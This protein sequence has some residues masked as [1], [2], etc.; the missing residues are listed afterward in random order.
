MKKQGGKTIY[1]YSWKND[2][3]EFS[4]FSY[5]SIVIEGKA[6][7]T[8]EHY[9]QSMKFLPSVMIEVEDDR[10]ISYQEHV[11]LA[12]T[13]AIAKTL[14]SNR[15]YKIYPDWD[16]RRI[17]VMREAVRAKFTQHS[18]LRELLQSTGDAVLVED[19]PYD[20][21]WGCGKRKTGKNMLGKIL[22]EV[23]EEIRD[24]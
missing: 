22:M 10:E 8:N 24:G 5:H 23:R 18:D 15:G 20:Y 2:Y 9:F 17:D 12:H 19:S 6:Y 21:F 16:S 14:G 3:F 4:N 11:R 13:P 1:F 7:A